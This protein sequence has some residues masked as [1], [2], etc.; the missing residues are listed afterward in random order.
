MRR[1]EPATGAANTPTVPI[2]R[3]K[4]RAGANSFATG[5]RFHSLAGREDV[6]STVLVPVCTR[7]MGHE[8]TGIMSA[9]PVFYATTEGHTRRIAETIA[10]IL[11]G[12]GFDSEAVRIAPGMR[13]PTGRRLSAPS[14]AA[15]CIWKA[16]IVGR[17]VSAARGRSPEPAAG[18]VLL[19]QLERGLPQ[20][21][22]SRSRR[23]TLPWR[24][25]G[26]RSG[27]RRGSCA[28]PASS[29]TRSTAS[30]LAG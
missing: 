17:R 18:G 6:A 20:S 11:R 3:A 9:V 22:R 2:G 15:R 29:P 28:L 19:G 14:S 23:A 25:S 12:Q 1:R 27:R 4:I 5:R 7:F 8:G 10:G 16:S 24:A 26:R 21:G 13:R 30:S